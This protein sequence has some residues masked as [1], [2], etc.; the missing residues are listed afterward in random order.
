MR[1]RQLAVILLVGG[2]LFPAATTGLASAQQKGSPSLSVYTPNNELTPGERQ[3]LTLQIANDGEIASSSDGAGNVVA[4][5]R[6][7]AVELRG[8]VNGIDIETDTQSIGSIQRGS[9]GTADFEIVTS[10]DIA[11]GTYDLEAEVEYSYTLEVNKFNEYTEVTVDRDFEVTVRVTDDARFAV[12][13]VESDVAIGQSGNVD[14][15]VENVGASPARDASVTLQSTGP[16][17]TFDGTASATRYIGEIRPGQTR[18]LSFE[19][20][21]APDSPMGDYALQ[22]TVDFEDSDGV[23]ATDG[24]FRVG[25]RPAPERTVEIEPTTTDLSVGTQGSVT[26]EITND[27]PAALRDATISARSTGETVIPVEAERVIGTLEPGGSTTVVY[28]LR[29]TDAA[30][31]GARQLTFDV[32]YENDAGDS[33]RTSPSDVVVEVAPEQSFSVT[34]IEHTLRVGS[35]GE[36]RGT[37]VNEGPGPARDAVLRLQVSSESVQPQET[38]YALGTLTPGDEASFSFPVDVTTSGSEG[39]R[40]FSLAVAYDT[41]DGTAAESDT[42]SARVDVA[43][44]RD[45]FAITTSQASVEAGSAQTVVLEVT[46]NRDVTL[47][48]VNAKAFVDAPLS[49]DTDE[50]YIPSIAPGATKTI[51][52]D[53]SAEGDARARAYPLDVDFQ[54][55]E[56]DGDT[57]LSDTYQVALEVT[58]PTEDGGLFATFG[59][60]LAVLGL[61]GLAGAAFIYTRR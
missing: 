1:T 18:T 30:E 27:G 26:L 33:Y 36:L 46:N 59:L 21:V 14:V 29:L 5:A 56:P 38:E 6:T 31:P 45:E 34:G 12:V 25:F 28:P 57:K 47:R 17:V 19:A 11:P 43:P 51:E 53:L 50:A 40:Q 54:Y 52:F 22:T 23:S 9:V 55:D 10:E 15:T 13:G 35:E 48:N 58:E 41:D 60:P 20:A 42:L 3:S 32:G 39:P 24:P 16:T 37:I 4:T 49:A 7:V 8:N 61:L 44:S 2:L